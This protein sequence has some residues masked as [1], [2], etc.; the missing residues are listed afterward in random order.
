MSNGNDD[1]GVPK[2][3]TKHQIIGVILIGADRYIPEK[4]RK[5]AHR[6]FYA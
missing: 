5:D 6:T 2:V 4:M 3:R 1:D